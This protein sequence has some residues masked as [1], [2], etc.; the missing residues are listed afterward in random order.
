MYSWFTRRTHDETTHELL[1][2]ILAELQRLNR[3]QR[4]FHV[5]VTPLV[6]WH[7]MSTNDLLTFKAQLSPLTAPH[8][9]V[10][11]HMKVLVG[12]GERLHVTTPA[13]VND[14][15]PFA[16]EQNA[17]VTLTFTDEDDAGNFSAPL[18]YDFVAIDQIPPDQPGG[19]SVTPVSEEP[20]SEYA[21]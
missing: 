20:G 14:F 10:T 2:A 21:G 1:R 15:E 6:E 13:D 19:V 16:V 7:A 12:G 3:P 5:I 17:D 11:R 18:V 8:D 9:V 4:P